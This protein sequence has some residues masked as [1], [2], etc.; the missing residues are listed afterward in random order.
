M[1]LIERYGVERLALRVLNSTRHMH[2]VLKRLRE[3]EEGQRTRSHAEL[4]E[5][6]DMRAD[7]DRLS[8]ELDIQKTFWE[9]RLARKEQDH[10]LR[11]RDVL[12]TAQTTRDRQEVVH[13]ERIDELR[14]KLD[15]HQIASTTHDRE[16]VKL[17]AQ[18]SASLLPDVWGL[19][20]FLQAN[21]LFDTNWARLR[22]LMECYRDGKTPPSTWR[23]RVD[24]DARESEA[25]LC[26]PYP[27]AGTRKSNQTTDQESKLAA[28]GA[29]SSGD[30]ICIASRPDDQ[31]P[32]SDGVEQSTRNRA[33]EVNELDTEVPSPSMTTSARISPPAQLQLE[34]TNYQPLTSRVRHPK[35]GYKES[36]E[37]ATARLPPDVC[38]DDLRLDVQ[39]LMRYGFSYSLALSRVREDREMHT[40]LRRVDLQPMLESMIYWNTPDSAIWAK[41]VP[42]YHFELALRNLCFPDY[43]LVKTHSRELKPRWSYGHY[44]TFVQHAP[45]DDMFYGRVKTFYFHRLDDLTSEMC[46]VLHKIIN[47]MRSEAQAYWEAQHWVLIDNRSDRD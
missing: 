20:D 44:V 41:F 47:F 3:L 16:M 30:T 26:E 45:W 5:L 42:R 7:R 40:L 12:A 39:A 31:R 28:H 35:T 11:M 32:A 1:P 22:D 21:T 6:F 15:A 9:D 19:L 24:V 33:A 4:L 34:P 8:R 37:E 18:V 46:L 38:W 13:R 43:C 23:T 17:R 10:E 29:N 36:E 2:L 27:T 25:N 14:A